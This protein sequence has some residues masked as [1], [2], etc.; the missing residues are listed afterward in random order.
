MRT[1]RPKAPLELTHAEREAWE[2]LAHRSRSQPQLARRARLILLC[3]DGL[4][5]NLVARKL[6]VREQTVSK[7]RGPLR[8]GSA[9]RPLR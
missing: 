2:S 6:H 3:G 8:S 9:G 1:G 5:S 4:A 7:W